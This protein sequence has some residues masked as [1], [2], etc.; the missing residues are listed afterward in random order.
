MVEKKVWNSRDSLR[1]FNLHLS[2]FSTHGLR[3][4]FF[5]IEWKLSH[6]LNLITQNEERTGKWCRPILD[7]DGNFKLTSQFNFFLGYERTF[8]YYKQEFYLHTTS[9]NFMHSRILQY[10]LLVQHCK[11][12]YYSITNCMI[13]VAE[14]KAT[15]RLNV[16][17]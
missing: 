10:F 12:M 5:W 8:F 13:L 2:Y 16:L 6:I 14:S 17:N 7:W 3:I 4:K 9:D 11:I 1:I 15:Y